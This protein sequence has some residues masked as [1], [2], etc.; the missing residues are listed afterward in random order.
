VSATVYALL[1]GLMVAATQGWPYVSAYAL[2][3]GPTVGWRYAKIPSK[4]A[5]A[6]S[7]GRGVI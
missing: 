2:L 4:Q 1:M 3:V 6:E 5:D 7:P